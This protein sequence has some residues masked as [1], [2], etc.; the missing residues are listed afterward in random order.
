NKGESEV[1]FIERMLGEARKIKQENIH[2]SEKRASNLTFNAKL[3]GLNLDK[4]TTRK[5]S[6]NL[7]DKVFGS[8]FNNFRKMFFHK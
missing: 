8:A 5:N 4:E 6:I 1:N 7:V 3:Q 2:S